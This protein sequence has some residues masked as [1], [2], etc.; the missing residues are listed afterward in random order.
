M[1]LKLIRKIFVTVNNAMLK[2][3][4]G[5]VAIQDMLILLPRC[6]QHTSCQQNVVEAL[7]NCK[8]C[9]KCPIAKILPLAKQYGIPAYVA[10]GS[11][12][13]VYVVKKHKTK[14]IVAV[15]CLRELMQGIMTVF[16]RAV[17]G[18]GNTCPEGPCKNTQ[19]DVG[20]VEK[21]IVEYG[22]PTTS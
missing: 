15:A 10:T 13:A 5:K 2:R 11:E 12:M 4:K 22:I 9:G 7:S 8:E 20:E 18:V 6:L 14:L 3:L 19:V 17:I 16:P 21:V 1:M